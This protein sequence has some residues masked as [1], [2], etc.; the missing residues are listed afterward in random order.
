MMYN[1]ID[2]VPL[3]SRF[4]I[5]NEC[6][7]IFTFYTKKHLEFIFNFHTHIVINRDM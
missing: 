1:K 4:T 5:D 3:C 6:M 7:Y 2:R